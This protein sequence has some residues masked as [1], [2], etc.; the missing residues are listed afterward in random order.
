MWEASLDRFVNLNKGEFRGRAA[1]LKQKET[2]IPRRFVTLEVAVKDGPDAADPWGNEPIFLD[3]Q[4][5]TMIGRAT[6][7]AYGYTMGKS[8]ALAYVDAAQSEPGTN[9]F[10][11]VL[12]AVLPA[13]VVAESPWDPNNERLRA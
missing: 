13:K 7:G 3:G 9:L 11:K 2:G 12:D 10:I 8:Y 5:K 6:S 4:Q 1:L